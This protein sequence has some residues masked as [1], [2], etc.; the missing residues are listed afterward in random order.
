LPLDSQTFDNVNKSHY[1]CCV[2]L[3]KFSRR[4]GT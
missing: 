4:R 1:L 2:H 3:N